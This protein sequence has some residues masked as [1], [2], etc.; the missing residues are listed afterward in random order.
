M[1]R[2]WT[3]FWLAALAQGQM[4]RLRYGGP[5][6][7]YHIT[8]ISGGSPAVLTVKNHVTWQQQHDFANGDVIY[9]QFVGGCAEANGFR[10][11]VNSNQQGG[12]FSITDL[13]G[14][15]IACSYPYQ[16]GFES[17]VVGKVGEYTLRSSRPRVFLPGSGPLLERSKD[18]DGN[19]PQVAPV[20]TE[21]DYPWQAMVAKYAAYI[22][23]GCDGR[24]P[25]LCPNEEAMMDAGDASG[26][27]GYGA[28][29]AA[30]IWFADNSKT[31]YLT[32]A[33]YMI[34]NLERAMLQNTS[35]VRPGFGFPCDVTTNSCGWGSGCDWLSI[36]MWHYSLAY[37]L[38]RDQLTDAERQAF[39]KKML[40][41]WGGEY[42]CSNQL[43]RQN[44][45]ANLTSGSHAVT[46][47]GFSVY[48]PGDGVYFK[49]SMAWGALGRWG[50]VVS[51]LSDSEMTVNFIIGTSKTAASD[52]TASNV[53]HYKV[54]PW[55]ETRCGAAF[56]AGGQGLAYN[57]GGAVI[58]RAIT[59]LASAID[60]SQTRVQVTHAGGFPAP[61]FYV[62]V[63]NEVLNVTAVNGTEWTVERGK[64]YTSAAPHATGKALEY[65]SQTSGG[66]FALAGP[67]ALAGEWFHNLTAQKA[68][69][70]M[71]TAFVL[72]GDDPRAA[73]Y[74][75]R[76][77]N[78]YYDTVYVTNKEYWSGPTQGG[79]QDQG[80][81]LGRWQANQIWAGL[82][83]RNAFAGSGIDLLEQYFWRGL[84]TILLWTPPN[85]TD[86]WRR[87]PEEVTT[88]NPYSTRNVGWAAAAATLWPSTE[89]QYAQYWLRN[90]SGLFPNPDGA[91]SVLYAA[92]SP[93]NSSQRDFRLELPPWSFHMDTDFNATAYYGLLV[94][95]RDWSE[96]SGM[97]V[98]GAGWNWPTDHTV[99]QGMYLPGGY[100]IFKGSKL[101]FGWDNAYGI[102][103][104]LNTSPWFR[105]G[106]SLKSITHPPWTSLASGGQYNQIDRRHG[107]GVYVYGRG[108]FTASWQAASKVLRHHRH[109]LHV[110]SDPEYVIIFDDAAMGAALQ[111]KTNLNYFLRG[112]TA[113]TFSASSDY[114][115]IVFKKPTEPGAMVSTKLLFPDGSEPTITYTQ[116][117]YSHKLTV[118]WGS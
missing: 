51:V 36:G 117:S 84:T 39:A 8:S 90:L 61:P 38:I 94:S 7:L 81:Q 23:E 105:L 48:S 12:T 24:T 58:Q 102:G 112:D 26:K 98:A 76:I 25:S 92:Y 114:R 28:H 37:D 14:T 21:N 1:S 104:D 2:W 16:S 67:R 5:Q 79:L 20:V 80:Y 107:D 22:T 63:E 52:V 97:L 55:S 44:G 82:V 30:Y 100:T 60:A 89:A 49:T 10:K 45:S 15:P 29:A 65:S 96:T 111:V 4:L 27:L 19:G 116:T 93:A 72:A 99:D 73:D 57:V 78:W 59:Y 87:M 41:G 77:W 91:H 75:E 56:L 53:D 109:F 6:S 108:N 50:Q 71:V 62:L 86:H 85:G 110:K 103:G 46:G 47:S 13:D 18:P 32:L 9:I 17:G 31:G 101:L 69:G 3:I 35:G 40:N 34:N 43:T 95:R 11:V 70:Y 88:G 115:D 33:R 54:M 83:G 42:E 106:G 113:Q 68:V 74:A 66:S 118:D 64:L